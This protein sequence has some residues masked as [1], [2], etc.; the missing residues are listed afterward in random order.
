MKN[1]IQ[2]TETDLK[3]IIKESVN[4]ILINEGTAL[5]SL[6]RYLQMP[7]EKKKLLNVKLHPHNFIYYLN[8]VKGLDVSE[9]IDVNDL[10]QNYG[11]YIDDYY[12]DIQNS[13]YTSIGS[14]SVDA[15]F[16]NSNLYM[17]YEGE[18]NGWLFHFTNNPYEIMQNGFMGLTN[19]NRI[20][21][22]FGYAIGFQR[23][24]G[25]GLGFA[26]TLENIPSQNIYRTDYMVIFKSPSISVFHRLDKDVQEIFDVSQVDKN[27]VYI[28]KLNNKAGE[29]YDDG[30]GDRYA[31]P[32]TIESM[33]CCFPQ[34]LKGL[35]VNTP[36]EAVQEI[37]K[38]TFKS[39]EKPSNYDEVDRIV[40]YFENIKSAMIR[41]SM[42]KI[43]IDYYIGE[44]NYF[45]EAF[46]PFKP[47]VSRKYF[48]GPVVE[49]LKNNGYE[50]KSK[51]FKSKTY[52][53]IC[54]L[55]NEKEDIKIT[56]DQH[57]ACWASSMRIT[58]EF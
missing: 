6:K 2:L 26:Y 46:Q 15:E 39:T 32:P 50:F 33:V 49:T 28:F 51:E 55:Y 57:L 3:Y 10:I 42:D 47:F 1:I 31:G 17:T 27:Q 11:E 37:E 12:Q 13:F 9:D 56:L 14:G 54:H 18:H 20:H 44:G 34:T 29:S 22:T 24:A 16:Q 52:S 53:Y 8:D 38:G 30:S 58:I 43:T 35:T 48:I 4:K 40:K 23:K 7:I 36:A 25:K 19:N 45:T 41:K 5:D 21:R